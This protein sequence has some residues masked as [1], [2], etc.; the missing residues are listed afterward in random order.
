MNGLTDLGTRRTYAD[1]AATVA[2]LFGCEE[3]FNAESFAHL[4]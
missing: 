2:D 4:L 1:I 3:R